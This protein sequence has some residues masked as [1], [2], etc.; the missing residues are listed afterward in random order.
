MH[1]IEYV[2]INAYNTIHWIQCIEYK[3]YNTMRLIKFLNAMNK[4]KCIENET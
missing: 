4:V 2:E 1:I 3:A